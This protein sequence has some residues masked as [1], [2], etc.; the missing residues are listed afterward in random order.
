MITRGSILPY[1]EG[2]AG[3]G[4]IWTSWI[5][6]ASYNKIEQN[7]QIPHKNYKRSDRYETNE[8]TRE[9]KEGQVGRL[10]G[11]TMHLRNNFKDLRIITVGKQR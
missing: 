4:R 5:Y 11:K 6:P 2:S 10:C 3:R 8:K 7:D 9:R 1:L